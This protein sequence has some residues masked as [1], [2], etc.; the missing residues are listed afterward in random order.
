MLMWRLGA[1]RCCSMRSRRRLYIE[2]RGRTSCESCE[3]GSLK[4]K[5]EDWIWDV[6]TRC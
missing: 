1:C 3:K 4:I 5:N 2:L 6:R